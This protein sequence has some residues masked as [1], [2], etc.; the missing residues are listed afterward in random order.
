[1]LSEKE[2]TRL[3]KVLSLILR[4]RPAFADITLDANG[5]A[6][7]PLLLRNLQ[8]KGY[9]IDFDILKHIVATNSKQ[10][11][12]LSEDLGRIRA[13][14]GHSVVID[15]DLQAAEP[16]HVLYHGTAARFMKTIQHEGLKKMGRHHVHLSRDVETARA[17]GTRHGVPV[18][19]EVAASRMHQDG[20]PFFISANG[21][22]L[23]D[24]VPA[25]Y[26]RKLA[27]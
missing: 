6:D 7:V 5:W 16:P 27:F 25:K 21:V 13:N 14:Q 11:F 15:L 20:Y 18:I 24:R 9:R 1:M 19:L 17:V 2:T 10:R 22:W 12:S 8:E 23:T 4:H 26:L 3:S